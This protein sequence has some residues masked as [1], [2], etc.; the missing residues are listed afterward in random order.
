MRIPVL[1]VLIVCLGVYPILAQDQI[2][3]ENDRIKIQWEKTDKGYEIQSLSFKSRDQWVAVNHPSGE[4]TFLYS[5]AQP[6]EK[7]EEKLFTVFGDDFP[8]KEYRYLLARW[9][10]RTRDVAL[11]TAGEAV[12]FYPDKATLL[13]K[14]K[15]SFE[16][17]THAIKFQ[18]VW[19]LDPEYPQDILI[20]QTAEIKDS[21]HYSFSSPTLTPISEEEL[22]WATVPGYFH[23]N[24]LGDDLAVAYAYGNGIPD[25]PII[26][27]ENTASTLSPMI[28]SKQGFTVAVIADPGLGR[29]PWEKDG[30]TQTDWHIGL[31]HMNRKSQLSPT[32]YYPVLG[33]P[34]SRL[35]QGDQLSFHFRISLHDKDWFETLNHAAY[36]IYDF[37]N[38]LKLRKN[39]QSLSSRVGTMH[40]YLTDPAT[41]L[42][43]VEEF[44]D[45]RIGAQAYLGGVVGSDKDAMKNA[46]Y[47][48]MWMLA[49]ATGD[50]QLTNDIL[51]Y[52]LNFKLAQQQVEAGFFQGAAIGQYYLSK[53][54]KFVEEWG[55]MVEPIALTYYIM[56]DIGNILL[57]EKE[58]EELKE[59]LR[60]GAAL[61]LDWQ[62][63]DGSWTVAYNR[64]GEELFPE[65]T[66]YR[67]TFY[68]LL[69]AYRI[70]KDERY[71]EAAI[72]G[73]D[74]YLEHG[75]SKGC[76]L[77]VC[78][79]V[80]YV[81]DF[82][83][84][85]T[86]QAY[87][88]LYE[89]TGK[90]A[91]KNAAVQAAKIY[92][93]HIYTHP[94]PTRATKTVKDQQLEDW[95]ISQAGLNFEHGGTLGSANS[96]GPILLA[97]HAG[98]FIRMYALTGE[99]IF[100]DM[101]RSAAIGRHAFVD[102]KTG[103]ASYYWR[104]MDA[105]PGPFP[106][107][108][109]WQIGWITDYLMSEVELRSDGNISFPRGFITPKVGPH[110]SYGFE[111]GT[112]FGQ[113]AD[114]K[115][116]PDGL[117][118][119]NPSL[120]HIVAATQNK[121]SILIVLLNQHHQ[122]QTGVATI[123]LPKFNKECNPDAVRVLDKKGN[124]TKTFQADEDWRVSVTPYGLAVLELVW[125]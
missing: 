113:K 71:L 21:G 118:I 36:D 43:R 111:P 102:K 18:T 107:H 68:G 66:D 59:R 9:D 108:A 20:H 10:E 45:K 104:N 28:T 87:L 93:T 72:K 35:E 30:I 103:V 48:A 3:L 80:R 32:L 117:K 2:Q 24:R 31:S 54:E 62:K 27:S 58:N 114:L 37:E 17:E 85:Q 101:A 124:V 34:Q 76:F 65:L 70:L 5:K 105:G 50:P 109:W 29:D 1:I 99:R 44:E 69:V 81:P 73:A 61:L 49:H 89:I 41:S 106:H 97:S 123:D 52:A 8:G 91:Y 116:L 6:A 25:R 46:D 4:H 110:Q 88:D 78:G 112:V 122:V 119:S 12:H 33:E 14:Q 115:I 92:T 83:T 67:S 60:L 82:A 13:G 15:I 51:P 90:A 63:P 56:L 98:M 100:V 22:E 125:E 77:G 96:H 84:A 64:K 40:G 75:V 23:G 7:A 120:E 121:K 39:K 11:N 94:I 16:K 86:A 79:D 38:G 53:S 55:D 57:F 19:E 74:W 47:G 95:E 26:F 42:W